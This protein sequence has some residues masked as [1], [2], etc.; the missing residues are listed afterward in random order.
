MDYGRNTL[1]EGVQTKAVP[2]ASHPAVAA[3]RDEAP[4]A[5]DVKPA[6]LSELSSGSMC[7]SRASEAR[8]AAYAHLRAGH[9]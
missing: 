6:N 5:L 1:S 8:S 4:A 3:D 9:L 7:L 2:D